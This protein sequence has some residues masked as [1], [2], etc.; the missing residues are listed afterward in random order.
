MSSIIISPFSI[1]I[2]LSKFFIELYLWDIIIIVISSQLLLIDFITF[3][4]VI[5]SRALVASSRIK[6]FGFL[7]IA[8][9]IPILWHCPPLSFKPLSP[10]IPEYEFGEFSIKFCMF[11][12]FEDFLTRF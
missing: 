12:I 4:S 3:F 8:L 6:I 11:A 9:A 2:T 5:L 7:Y 10:T 1:F